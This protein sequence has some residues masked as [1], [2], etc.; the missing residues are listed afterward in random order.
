EGNGFAM[1]ELDWTGFAADWGPLFRQRGRMEFLSDVFVHEYAHIVSLKAFSPWSEAATAMEVGGLAEDEEWLNR[2]GVNPKPS[3][4]PDI[5]VSLLIG[6]HTPFWWAEGGAEYWSDKAGYN[7]WGDSRDAFLR[8]TVLEDRLLNQAEWTTRIDKGG[9]DG[10][11]GYNQGYS[12]GLYLRERFGRDVMSEM[13][14]IS[15]ERWHYSWDKVVKKATGEDIDVLYADWVASLEA[16]YEAQVAPIRARGVV[17]GR[18]LSLTEPPWEATSGDGKKDWD[19]LSKKHQD[20]LIDAEVSWQEMPSYSPDG[21]YLAWS[22]HG[23]VISAAEP[24]EWGAIG[25]KYFDEDA[26]RLAEINKASYFEDWI[27]GYPVDWSPDS[28]H[29]VAVGSE[30]HANRFAMNQGLTF[31]GDGYSWNQLLI[32]T[33]D[34]SNKKLKVDWEPVPNTLR[35]VEAAWAPDGQTIAFARY[36]DGTNDLWT[37]KFDGTDATRFSQFGDGTQIQG[38][39]WVDEHRVMLG[40]YREDRQDLWLF[41]LR[42]QSWRRLTD[43]VSDETDAFVGPDG[44]VWFGANPDGFF[45]IYDLDIDSMIVRKQT[46]VLGGA[47]AAEVSKGGHLLFSDFTGHGMRIKAM[48]ADKRKNEVVDYAGVCAKDGCANQLDAIGSM[49]E[50][51]DVRPSSTK[52]SAL[53][54]TMPISM[55]PTVRYTDRNMQIGAS[56]STGD[57]VEKHSIDAEA[58]FGKDSYFS[59]NYYN[60][61]FWPSLSF[62]YSRYAYK[63]NYGY[64]IDE[65]GLGSTTDDLRVVDVKFEQVSDDLYASM[66]YVPSDVTWIS[67]YGDWSRYAFRG[68]T[69]GDKWGPYLTTGGVG[70]YIEWSPRGGGY[71][72]DDWINPRGGR[73]VY[74]DYSY[75]RTHVVDRFSGGA[76]Y[77]DGE[78]L[79]D[80]SFH[81]VQ[82]SWTEFV[83]VPGTH[84]HTLQLDLDLGYINRNVMGWDEFIAGGRHPYNWGNGTIGNNMQFSGYEGWS[85]SGETMIIGNAAWRFPIAR[86]LNFKAG[87]VYTDSIYMQFFGTAGNLWSYRVDGPSHTQGGSVVPDSPGS[88][89]REVPFK[90]YASKNSPSGLENHLLVDVGAE[91]R[92]RAFIWNDWDWDGFVRASYGLQPTSGYGDV[93]GDM[94]QSSLARDA[95]SELSAEIEPATLRIYVGLG[96]GW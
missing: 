17:Q 64:G 70:T 55:F 63:G 61:M 23:L 28:K 7:V 5:G 45:N 71:W 38:I 41:D 60:D 27:R 90:D 15:G 25:G 11:R 62:G 29:L 51:A 85:L 44:H 33:L 36:S 46:D 81:K 22:E 49:V 73:R 13:A 82:A 43:S 67:V 56:L 3:I 95:A 35:A 48:H 6:T 24:K 34:T 21:K 83:P 80:Y 12:F 53:K 31:N 47:Y 9:F 40:L 76:V 50:V 72:G 66:S 79:E 87:P 19:K 86:D 2:W 77:D 69:D 93:N 26:D 91:V 57:F 94:I 84:R 14:T 59:V 52:Y 16:R 75:R 30:D 1:A 96:T 18:E 20:E 74:L 89:R 92:V 37:I 54:E 4:N 32:G 10:E 42:D 88:A 78:A 39:D 8:T 65:D 68:P 58:T